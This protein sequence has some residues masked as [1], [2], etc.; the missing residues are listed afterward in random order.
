M[1]HGVTAS[2]FGGNV[3]ADAGGLAN[4]NAEVGGAGVVVVAIVQVG[5]PALRLS[6]CSPTRSLHGMRTV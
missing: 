3:L 1:V 4:A 5:A 6:C 2:V